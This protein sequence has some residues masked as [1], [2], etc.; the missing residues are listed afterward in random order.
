MGDFLGESAL[1]LL[2]T[3]LDVYMMRLDIADT[4]SLVGFTHPEKSINPGWETLKFYSG[5]PKTVRTIAVATVEPTITFRF[6]QVAEP[7]VLE[8]ALEGT[9]VTTDPNWDFVFS[10]SCKCE[11]RPR[12]RIRWVGQTRECEPIEFVFRNAQLDVP[13]EIALGVQD[14][15]AGVDMTLVLMPDTSVACDRDLWYMRRAKAPVSS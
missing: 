12:Y 3:H 10:G 2:L 15:W 11:P 8:T 9:K 5:T 14:D 6:A 4:E 13:P 1:Q 7:T